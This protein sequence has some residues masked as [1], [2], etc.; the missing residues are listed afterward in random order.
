MTSADDSFDKD[1]T[2]SNNAGKDTPPSVKLATYSESSQ[3]VARAMLLKTGWRIQRYRNQITFINNDRGLY[4][5]S[6]G[7]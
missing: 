4:Y 3:E 1:D 5:T 7:L 2:I 6:H